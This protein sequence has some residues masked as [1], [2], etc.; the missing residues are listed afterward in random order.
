MQDQ[1]KDDVVVMS[2][3][4]ACKNRELLRNYKIKHES[5]VLTL[6]DVFETFRFHKQTAIPYFV[7]IDTQHNTQKIITGYSEQLAKSIKVEV[8]RIIQ[9]K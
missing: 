3:N 5:S 9:R 2:I 4:S 8:N 6:M 1:Y 7:I